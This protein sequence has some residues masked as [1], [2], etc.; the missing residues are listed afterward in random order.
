M[1][2]SDGT[3]CALTVAAHQARRAADACRQWEEGGEPDRVSE[4]A[5]LARHLGSIAIEAMVSDEPRGDPLDEPQ[6]RRGKLAYAAWLIVLAGTDEG[7]QS[8][9][10]IMAA[11]LFERATLA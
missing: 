3:G 8:E 1:N 4:T 6:T 10:L 7:G 2:Q 5:A 9:D 11:E